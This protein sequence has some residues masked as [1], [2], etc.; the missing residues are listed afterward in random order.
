MKKLDLPYFNLWK[1]MLWNKLLFAL[2][3]T[4]TIMAHA[5]DSIIS[6]TVNSSEGESLPGV[7]VLVKSTDQGTIT[8]VDG[9]F[10]INA[11]EDA[12]LVFSFVGY[13]SKEVTLNGQTTIEVTL[14]P[15]VQQLGEIVV[16]GY[17]TESREELTTSV[18]KVDTKVLENV[19]YANPA[20]ALQGNVSGVRVQTTTGQ[21]GAS[22]RI[23]VRGGTSINNPN[24][25]SPLYVIDGVI[26]N[27]MD[28][29]DANNIESMQVLKDAASTSIYGARGSNGVVVITTKNGE[30]GNNKITYNYNLM[31]SKVG[32]TYDMVPARDFIKFYRESVVAISRKIPERM[33]LLDQATPGG[34]GNDLTAA[35]SYTTQYLTPENEHKLNEGWESM[36]DPVD[37]SKTIIFQGT[38]WQDI[39]FQTG[40]S[41]EHFLSFSG[42]TQKGT[43]SLG[44]GY[45]D[46][47]G[48]AVGTFYK[49]FSAK[50]NGELQV[51][52]N[53][54]VYSRLMYSK[55]SHR[56]EG[57]NYA[58][59]QAIAPTAK[60]LL[61][62]G[63]LAPSAHP[64]YR[65]PE[66]YNNSQDIKNGEDNLTIAVGSKWDILPGLS[67]EPQ[68]SLFSTAVNERFFQKA[69]YINNPTI[70][71]D[72][73]T[74][75]GYHSDQNQY[76]A[77]AI[78]AYVKSFNKIHNLSVKGGFSYY[79]TDNN[80]L[81]ARGQGAASDL[82]PTLN[83]SAVPVSVDGIESHQ[84]ILGYFSRINYNFDQKYLFS[85]NARYDGA[86]NLGDEYKWGFF[87]GISAGWNMHREN[88][89]GNVPDMLSRLKLRGSYGVNGNISGLGYYE[90]QGVYSV[91]R[92]Y[93]TNSAVINSDL[94]NPQLQ[95]ER[96]NTINF[97]IDLGLFND[98]ITIISDIYRRVTDNLLTD[99]P[100]PPSTGFNNVRTNL[101]S[102]ENKGWEFELIANILPAQSD[103][104][105]DASF[106]VSFVK[107]KILELPDN[108]V[109]NNR[110]GGINIW[111]P[112]IQD[113]TWAGGLQEGQPIGNMY[114]FV[115]E[116]IYTTDEEALADPVV[117][118]IVTVT[119][120]TKFGGDVKWLDVDDN[121][122]IDLRDRVYMGNVY[123]T[124]TGG[125]SNYFNY[126]NFT[127]GIRMDYTLGHTKYD[128][129]R[130]LILAVYGT[131]SGLTTDAYNSW[132]EPGDV[133]QYPQ[134][135]WADQQT[136]RNIARTQGD[137]NGGSSI[138]YQSGD[139][140][141]LREI[142]LSYSFPID[143][144]Q[145]IGLSNL[146]INVT[147]NN[148]H[149]FTKFRGLSP[150][151][152]G[153]D[154]G[155]YPIPK[156]LIFGIKVGF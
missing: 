81:S 156:N 49:R 116:K 42:G 18:S 75:T 138:F 25:A 114:G 144:I 135:Y 72:S 108:G 59:G 101:G 77:D 22:P 149:Y 35:T 20:S 69:S 82:I 79:K 9:N 123:P 57:W 87:P 32:N 29:I 121:G 115:Q 88:F 148:L 84:L 68:L 145:K 133:A 37:P 155:T 45:L 146:S 107:N 55:S 34:T 33:S 26:R 78:L 85:L 54:S 137:I 5:Q 152:G 6:G 90:A 103:F 39:L 94:A 151:D 67:F 41:H 13:I 1:V 132:Q 86:S 36:P 98:R 147:G 23:I 70:Y 136:Q 52:D 76:Q 73:R 28:N 12:T 120:K 130:A 43:Y 95:W 96:S 128:W 139:Y 53:L 66:Y 143:I 102:L 71:V 62:D 113:Y 24:G 44:L 134:I 63:S 10:R 61:E 17:G 51:R 15:D 64:S 127:L 7:N 122:I 74:A 105:W 93:G 16:I 124:W 91:G 58:R 112:S 117:D 80:I 65:N 153:R 30:P 40:V 92:Q 97:G 60:Y 27:D 8:D 50:F 2:L 3:I 47:E 150:E 129:S 100:L 125:I 83:A 141:A 56:G 38:D 14:N 109:E 106:N 11:P 46:N 99:L 118:Q 4:F 104:Q 140:L 111:D 131:R 19:P 21:P 110:V 119:D 48:T 89:W 154:S 126:K 31:L 142:S